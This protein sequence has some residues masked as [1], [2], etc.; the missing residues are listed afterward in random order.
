MPNFCADKF[1]AGLKTFIFIGLF[2]CCLWAPHVFA[3]NMIV[4][5]PLADYDLMCEDK[6]PKDALLYA[7]VG[8]SIYFNVKSS[9]KRFNNLDRA[10]EKELHYKALTIVSP[11]CQDSWKIVKFHGEVIGSRKKLRN[12]CKKF[13]SDIVIWAELDPDYKERLHDSLKNSEDCTL[14]LALY[15]YE[16]GEW[17]ILTRDIVITFKPERNSLEIGSQQRISDA[18]LDLMEEIHFS[19]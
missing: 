14:N 6:G 19:N 2:A 12:A 11:G 8:K 1:F 5:P 15:A 10:K 18:S 7:G 4:V 13:Q 9:I 16:K 17:E 3:G